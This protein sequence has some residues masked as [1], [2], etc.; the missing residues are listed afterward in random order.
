[1]DH[2]SRHGSC[3]LKLTVGQEQQNSVHP[4]GSIWR[5]QDPARWKHTRF[6]QHLPGTKLRIWKDWSCSSCC[7]EASGMI[8]ERTVC[9]FLFAKGLFL[10]AGPDICM[11][12]GRDYC[13]LAR[14]QP[15]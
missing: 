7:A 4:P 6:S 8:L 15:E 5:C 14:E 1:M 11:G 2:S 13:D 9:V 10:Q 12:T 3:P